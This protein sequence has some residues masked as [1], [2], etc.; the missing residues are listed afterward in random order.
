M[1]V[2]GIQ[3][4]VDIIGSVFKP[5]LGYLRHFCVKVD[6]L[7]VLNKKK[8]TE[9]IYGLV[10]KIKLSMDFCFFYCFSH[11]IYCSNN[12]TIPC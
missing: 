1:L 5:F 11:A 4:Q 9:R 10:I 6:N 7:C 8:P 2:E 12:R 3:K